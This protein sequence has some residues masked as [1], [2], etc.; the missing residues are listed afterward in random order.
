MNPVSSLPDTTNLFIEE[1]IFGG[2]IPDRENK[3]TLTKYFV[4]TCP[5]M[6]PE[7]ERY[8]RSGKNLLS[9]FEKPPPGV[10][11]AAF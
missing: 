2:S 8:L 6:C 11:S 7:R 9:M 4:G 10:R 5:D 3:R 1:L